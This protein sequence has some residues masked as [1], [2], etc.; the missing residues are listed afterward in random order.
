MKSGIKLPGQTRREFGIMI[1]IWNFLHKRKD[2]VTYKLKPTSDENNKN[3]KNAKFFDE[4]SIS[5]YDS[6]VFRVS[7]NL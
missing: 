4:Y 6:L 5:N 2:G 1:N 3:K 7:G